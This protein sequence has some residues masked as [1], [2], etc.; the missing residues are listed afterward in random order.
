MQRGLR[1]SFSD[2]RRLLEF[3]R[4][5]KMDERV[6]ESLEAEQCKHAFVF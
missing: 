3:E 1:E 4:K 2:Y 6:Q 5:A